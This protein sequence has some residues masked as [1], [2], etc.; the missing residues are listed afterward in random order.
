MAVLPPSGTFIVA[1]PTHRAAVSG[2][3]GRPQCISVTKSHPFLK[4][5]L[6]MDF[7]C[8]T[9]TWLKYTQG[10][11]L[12]GKPLCTIW[13]FSV[14][15]W[16][17][18]QLFDTRVTTSTAAVPLTDADN[19]WP[20][21]AT[22]ATQITAC[23]AFSEVEAG[24]APS[25]VSQLPLGRRLVG[26]TATALA[27]SRC[28]STPWVGSWSPLFCL[29]SSW[30]GWSP[31][32]SSQLPRLPRA[33][34]AMPVLC[35]DVPEAVLAVHVHS[36]PSYAQWGSCAECKLP[37]WRSQH[38]LVAKGWCGTGYTITQL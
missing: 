3:A 14:V 37:W 26:S 31:L 10:G 24:A 25:N 4:L 15:W 9:R 11:T 34:L 32:G 20:H 6:K 7:Y 13:G 5:W 22:E 2:H 21:M 33:P 28:R 36:W 27:Q 23:E 29:V 19:K 30:C 16:T 12:L 17:S 38:S 18:L 35:N 8:I 1:Y